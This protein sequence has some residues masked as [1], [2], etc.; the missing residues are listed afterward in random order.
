MTFC[1]CTTGVTVIL[2]GLWLL[3][4]SQKMDFEVSQAAFWSLSGYKEQPSNQ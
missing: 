3:Q 1:L 2:C 4:F